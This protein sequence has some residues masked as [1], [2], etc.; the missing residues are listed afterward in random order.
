MREHFSGKLTMADFPGLFQMLRS[1]PSYGFETLVESAKIFDRLVK[2][3]NVPG[4]VA[5]RPLDIDFDSCELIPTECFG[6]FVALK[7]RGDGNCCFRAASILFFGSE[8]R[9][10][11]IRVRTII[12]LALHSF[13]YL[14]DEDVISRMEAEM[15]II[16]GKQ[17]PDSVAF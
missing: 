5:Y 12:I 16:Q 6:E 1:S 13:F 17:T 7:T 3:V 15:A 2:P 9:H 4:E 14:A 8:E 10:L 11:E